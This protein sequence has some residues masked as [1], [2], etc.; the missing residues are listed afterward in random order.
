MADATT[1]VEASLTEQE[2]KV[3][4]L[5]EQIKE[6]EEHPQK[7]QRKVTEMASL[8]EQ[9]TLKL[10]KHKEAAEKLTGTPSTVDS[11]L[12][13]FGG[14]VAEA[15]DKTKGEDV[16]DQSIFRAHAAKYEV[17]SELHE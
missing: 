15:L 4:K 13:L 17:H 12:D 8:I 11:A 3:T 7:D 6:M 1:A 16:T 14:Y 10:T 5:K 2:D 9:E